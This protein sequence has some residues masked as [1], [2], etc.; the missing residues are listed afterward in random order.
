M[1]NELSVELRVIFR[2]GR[3]SQSYMYISKSVPSAKHLAFSA[4]VSLQEFR[5]KETVSL[6]ERG[7]PLNFLVYTTRAR[8]PEPFYLH[9][10]LRTRCPDPR[11]RSEALY[12]SPQPLFKGKRRFDSTE[13]TAPSPDRAVPS[14]RKKKGRA[15]RVGGDQGIVLIEGRSR[16][17]KERSPATRREF[18]FR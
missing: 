4:F 7:S 8:R 9:P 18:P 3:V 12:K 17:V 14:V 16:R 11:Y 15:K 1:L 13:G 2:R 10:G 6:D 5:K